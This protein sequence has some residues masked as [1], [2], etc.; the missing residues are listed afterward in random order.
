[1]QDEEDPKDHLHMP[2][3]EWNAANKWEATHKERAK[4]PVLIKVN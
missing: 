1:M 2:Q 3:V 4:N